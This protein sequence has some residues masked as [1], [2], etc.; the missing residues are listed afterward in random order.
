MALKKLLNHWAYNAS[1]SSLDG[2]V[3]SWLRAAGL[4]SALLGAALLSPARGCGV[5]PVSAKLATT[6]CGGR[7]RPVSAE[8]GVAEL[9]GACVARPALRSAGLV[10]GS[11]QLVH[12]QHL[13]SEFV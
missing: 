12:C 5:R 6:F 8:L 13:S 9:V 4:V 7:L 1:C 2:C 3:G 10:F 11:W